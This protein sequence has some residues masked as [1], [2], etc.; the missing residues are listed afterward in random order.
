VT[1]AEAFPGLEVTDLP[2]LRDELLRRAALGFEQTGHRQEAAECWQALGMAEQASSL[3]A[4]AG[5][6][7]RA[8]MTLLQAKHYAQALVLYQ[9]WE[10]QIAPGDHLN[11]VRCLLG[12]AACHLLGLRVSAS[13]DGLDQQTSGQAYQAA[14]AVLTS[15]G[16][17]SPLLAARAWAA[18]GE[19]GSWLA[20][21]DLVQ[22][23]YE[24]ALKWLSGAAAQ[25]QP[26]ELT[27]LYLA[28]ARDYQDRLLSR[29]LED[30]LA[31][32]QP[33]QPRK[34][35]ERWQAMIEKHP[36]AGKRHDV[37]HFTHPEQAGAWSKLTSME[38][39]PDGDDYL[40]SLA[41]EDMIY[42]P[43][44]NF[45]MGNDE[46]N[47]EADNDEHPQH[48][49][50]LKG[51]YI[52]RYPVTNAQYRLFL[53][54]GGYG[55]SAYWTKAGW[56][57]K[58]QKEWQEPG[59]WQD[60]RFNG[61][62]QPVVGVS[63]HEAL[64]YAR[65]AAQSLPNEP[66][67][68]K[69]ASWDPLT[70]HKRRYPWGDVWDEHK[71]NTGESNDE[72]TTP[73]ER[74]SP[75][76]DSAYGVADLAGNVKEWCLSLKLDSY[77]YRADDGREDLEGAGSRCLRGDSWNSYKEGRWSRCCFRDSVHSGARNSTLG[78]RCVIRT[79]DYLGT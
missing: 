56:L 74:Y 6:L 3:F 21:Y 79:I 65:W 26:E 70:Q 60:P 48:Q 10:R 61:I 42:I 13:A 5:D 14:R 27:R 51:Y 72:S 25:N 18:L 20:R 17:S 67:W 30:Q 33:V 8:A 75:Q 71:C 62:R 16:A 37:L 58:E 78:F 15:L 31:A 55:Q 9:T 12:Q 22:E 36:F 28:A 54:A 52:S 29:A 53:E 43:A 24:R 7:G 40:R 46:N 32:A 41:P 19:Y 23:G 68:E 49:L 11:R 44:G 76:G 77:P 59:F 50:W 57:D 4:L 38:S 69:A 47:G 39:E 35:W 66:E 45:L 73:V 64:A 34:G 2:L 1:R 63:W